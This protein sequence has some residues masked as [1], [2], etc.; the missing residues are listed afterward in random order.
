M[1]RK[2]RSK[3]Q[4]VKLGNVI[5]RLYKRKRRTT[6]GK[7]RTVYEIADYTSGTRRFRGFSDHAAAVEAANDIGQKIA[8]GNVE[9]ASMLN[10]DAASYGRAVELLRPTAVTLE[11]AAATFAKCFEI[12]GGDNL[13]D[14]ARHYVR[15]NADQV[16]R[17]A[18]ADVVFKF[19]REIVKPA[20]AAQWFSVTPTT[21]AAK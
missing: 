6:I 12:L 3:P 5:V 4:V 7:F 8:S 20:A 15:H 10:A 13:V 18:V 1:K 19:Y 11:L 14:A 2:A 21:A 17:R 9:A 16:T